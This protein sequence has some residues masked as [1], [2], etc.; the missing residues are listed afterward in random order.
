MSEARP[1]FWIAGGEYRID[2]ASGD[3]SAKGLSPAEAVARA[4]SGSFDWTRA[5]LGAWGRTLRHGFDRPPELE[6]LASDLGVWWLADAP[7]RRF[8]AIEAV[9]REYLDNLE[10]VVLDGV[11]SHVDS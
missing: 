2:V 8:E 3:P 5:C 11:V 6:Q 9:V 1:N 7:V 4:R 10:R